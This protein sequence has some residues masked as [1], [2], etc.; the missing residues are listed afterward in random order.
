V[1]AASEIRRTPHSNRHNRLIANRRQKNAPSTPTGCR[2][3]SALLLLLLPLLSPLLSLPPHQSVVKGPIRFHH[4]HVASRAVTCSIRHPRDA[5][6]IIAVVANDC[7]R[8]EI[9][10]SA[11]AAAAGVREIRGR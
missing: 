11:A 7:S 1:N 10:A 4:G 3:F 8:I 2:F 5:G 9:L 6:A